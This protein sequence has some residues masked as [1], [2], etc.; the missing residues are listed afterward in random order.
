[1]DHTVSMVDKFKRKAVLVSD[2][3][4]LVLP[5]AHLGDTEWVILSESGNRVLAEDII[6]PHPY[7]HFRRS[8]MDGFAII[9]NDT[10][11]CSSTKPIY[12]EVV[13]EI[14]CGS[15]PSVKLVSG[16]AAR[17][18]TGAKVPDEADAVVMFEMTESSENRGRNYIQLKREIQQGQN[19]T[20]IGLELA[21]GDLILEKGRKLGA[22]EISVLATFGIHKVPVIKKPRVA[23]ISTGS[24]LLQIDEPLQ[25]GRIRNSNTFMLATQVKETGAEPHILKTISDDLTKAK[26]R[27]EE[28]LALYDVV[29]TTGGVS[30][31]DFDIMADLVT[32][33]DVEML[34]NKITMRPGSV[35]TAAVKNGKLLFALSGNPGACFIG[36]ELFARPA[37]GRMLGVS[38]PFLPEF[39]AEL[40]RT[41]SKIN[42]YTRFVRGRLEIVDGRVFVYPAQ[43]DE[44]SV[45][46]TIKDSDVLIVIP[47]SNEGVEA[48]EMVNVIKLPGYSF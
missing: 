12:L 27:V 38:N 8:G 34:F 29:I 39:K 47:P 30:V 43:L 14:P 19:I 25:D 36:F 11:N 20:K 15:L 18:M 26:Q 10:K 42:N 1:M 16:T 44:S 7:P 6:A 2:A 41:Y 17:I 13:D 22:G 31:G 28:A 40:G 37:I 21:E 46:I 4:N 45:M 9:S 5:H 24:E 35:T 48:G 33:D 23:I 3:Q 32:G